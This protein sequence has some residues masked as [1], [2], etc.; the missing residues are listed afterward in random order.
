MPEKILLIVNPVSGMGRARAVLS[1]VVYA[2]CKGG[3]A[4]TVVLT[5]YA[6]HAEKLAAEQGAHADVVACVG[7][8]GTLSDVIN[9][10][11]T[12]QEDV[13]PRVGYIPLGTTNDMAA[14]MGISRQPHTAARRIVSGK[15]RAV[16]VGYGNAGW[17]GYVMAFGAFT[18]VPFT[19]P[20]E[21]KNAFGRLAYFA[22][23]AASIPK[24]SAHHLRVEH[25][26]GVLEGDYIFGAVAN[27]TSVAGILKLPP[28]EAVLDD[29]LLEVLLVKNPR[30]PADL[31]AQLAGLISQNYNSSEALTLLHTSHVRIT[32]AE[33]VTWTRDGENGGS[34]TVMEARVCPKAIQIMG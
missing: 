9:G 30:T 4:V 28:K 33:P 5:E 26:G 7:G 24:L 23:G 12:M 19:T 6:G 8:D 20:Q 31:N 25:D 27:S 10:L 3:N 18:Q 29:G 21:S 17:F 16:D 14:S 34:H 15:A 11:M 22:E 32:G 13:R 2:L 1:G